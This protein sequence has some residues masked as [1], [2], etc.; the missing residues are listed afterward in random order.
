MILLNR[1]LTLV[2]LLFFLV[3]LFVSD[4][5]AKVA[6]WRDPRQNHALA[7]RA[8]SD[9]DTCITKGS[10]LECATR[11]ENDEAKT[12]FKGKSVVATY[13]TK[14]GLNT[15]GWAI[16]PN[17]EPE[18]VDDRERITKY[19]N[20]ISLG[21][22]SVD[23]AETVAV[24]WQWKVSGVDPTT[25]KV[26]T[27]VASHI[28]FEFSPFLCRDDYPMDTYH[29]VML[30]TYLKTLYA[31]DQI[32]FIQQTRSVDAEYKCWYNVAVGLII[33]DLAWS[34]DY[35]IKQNEDE[36]WWPA[37]TVA[38]AVSKLSDVM[39]IEWATQA[40]ASATT[41]VTALKYAIQLNVV[42]LASRGVISQ[43]MK[44]KGASPGTFKQGSTEFQALLGCPNGGAQAW[45]LINHK[46][47][48]GLKTI[49]S[50]VIW[51]NSDLIDDEYE[52]QDGDTA[53]ERNMCWVTV[54]VDD[55]E[56]WD[57]DSDEY[58]D[59]GYYGLCYHMLFTFTDVPSS[60]AMD[61]S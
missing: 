2:T 22:K 16:V 46:D 57:P 24:D 44:G 19:L 31:N 21:G 53:D 56:D 27:Y 23:M 11:M 3:V 49:S 26:C 34:P 5:W 25:Q 38:P 37:G 40:A 51:T 35:I 36:A 60:D 39:Y 58:P 47:T 28:F 8:N 14:D 45:V 50:I 17:V 30:R 61:L 41:D 42:N 54:E 15:A 1:G 12:Y 9:Y 52:I 29:T 7:R 55:D 18:L 10:T 20:G 4:S 32:L 33:V 48:L 6:P 43:A 13:T 59:G